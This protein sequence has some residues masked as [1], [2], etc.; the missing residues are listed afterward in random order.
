MK[1]TFV[2][3]VVLL[4]VCGL[5]LNGICQTTADAQK[6]ITPKKA[7]ADTNYDGNIDRTEYYDDNGMVMKVEVDS[8]FDGI[9]DETVYYENGKPVKSAKDTNKDGKPD[10]WAEF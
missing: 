2:A 10:M 3:I 5:A 7:T 9:I 4:A 1:K 6:K 8:D